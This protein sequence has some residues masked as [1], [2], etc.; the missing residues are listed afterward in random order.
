MLLKGFLFIKQSIMVL[1]LCSFVL[2][3]PGNIFKPFMNST[4]KDNNLEN[5]SQSANIELQKTDLPPVKVSGT[6]LIINGKPFRF[7]GAN[8]IYFGFYKEYLFSIDDAIRSAKE[9][10]INV[11]RI[12]LG[13]GES[14]WNEK[15]MEEYDRAVDIAGRNGMYVIP[16][17]TDCCCMGSNWSQ[18]LDDYY[19]QVPYCK[20]NSI[21]SLDAYKSFIKKILLR[22]NTS[23]GK[24]YKDDSTIMA[25]DI[26]NEPYLL[27]YSSSEVSAWI[28]Q[29]SEYIKSVDPNHL[30]TFGLDASSDL[31]NSDGPQ[32]K[33]LDVPTLD[34][35]SFHFNQPDYN[36]ALQRLEAIQFRVEMFRSMGKPVILEEFGVGSQRIFRVY[37]D[38]ATLER[39]IASYKYQFDATFS[40]GASGAMF[41][42]WGIPETRRVPLWWKYEDHDITETEFCNLI[43]EYQIP[44][45]GSFNI[46]NM[47]LIPPDDDFVGTTIDLSK[48]ITVIN[49]GGSVTQNDRMIMQVSGSSANSNNSVSSTWA[50][51]GDFDI[52]I[53]FE[54]GQGWAPPENDHLDGAALG[55]NIDGQM[56][57]ITRLRSGS[58]DTFFA[59]SSD[60]RLSERSNTT[61]V[62]GKYRLVRKGGD[63]EFSYDIGGGWKKLAHVTVAKPVAHVYFT[64]G[65][66]NT[67]QAFTTYF[68]NFRVNSGKTTYHQIDLPPIILSDAKPTT[69]GISP[70]SSPPLPLPGKEVISLDIL[71]NKYPWLSLD[72]SARPSVYYFYFNHLKP[73]FNNVLV[74]Q[75]FSAAT[76]R[77]V[78]AKVANEF[79]VRNPQ[80][81]TSFT[82]PDTLGRELY[83]SVGI[84]FNPNRAKTLLAQAGYADPSKFPEVTLL[85]GVS[86]TDKPGYHEKIAETITGMW[87]KNL[88]VKVKVEKVDFKTFS[89][90]MVA[91]PPEIFRSIFFPA[92]NDPEDFMQN[93]ITHG[94]FNFGGYSNPGYDLLIDQ[95]GKENDPDIRQKDYILAEKLLNE[96][97]TAILPIIHLIYP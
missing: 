28:S 58:E 96:T 14:T 60:G 42:G 72:K 45:I 94:K 31:Y 34:F 50:L 52:Q 46:S 27:N 67:S 63:L 77:E 47:P 84:S 41:W 24:I 30:V 39:W 15:P 88:D 17:L 71:G 53:D 7:I 2:I 97:D 23:N 13:F 73:P 85:I 64:N 37:P 6:D 43:R 44:A 40:A 79:G 92:N 8:S 59:W 1:V 65:S 49:G 87:Q 55:V 18:T 33:A 12:D 81:A 3:T 57:H 5:F 76:D 56:F 69:G 54:I 89:N 68:D 78:L 35:F 74:R 80:P 95:A 70:T 93:F 21:E 10:G 62:K 20:M 25:W 32:Y 66:V 16:I 4:G 91:N 26:A 19:K 82:P 48:W 83:N 36:T 22:K 38:Q 29:V 61:S 86:D 9:N 90:R 51:P 75:A 11:L